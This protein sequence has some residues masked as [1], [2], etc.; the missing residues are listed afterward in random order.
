MKTLSF[1]AMMLIFTSFGFS[2]NYLL[3]ENGTNC[4]LHVQLYASDANGSCS[5]VTATNYVVSSGAS[6]PATAPS[7]SEWVYAE[8]VQYPF[9]T[10]CS[11]G[12]ALDT[13][14][15]P[16]CVT[17]PGYGAPTFAKVAT[18]GCNGCPSTIYMLWTAYCGSGP[19]HIH[20]Y[21]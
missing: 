19:G 16:S 20:F 14:G 18:G 12:Q 1:L 15:Y 17:C 6:V 10:G 9:G 7:G 11:F 8:I 13:D 21:D 2:Q 5:F 4:D 3:L